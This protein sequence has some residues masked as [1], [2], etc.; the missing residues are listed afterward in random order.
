MSRDTSRH[1]ATQHVVTGLVIDFLDD[2]TEPSDDARALPIIQ[3][4]AAYTSWCE[5]KG[6]IA[7]SVP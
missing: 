7:T 3:L 4:Y 2:C 6:A 1:D 5:R